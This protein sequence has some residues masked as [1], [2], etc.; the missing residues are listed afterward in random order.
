MPAEVAHATLPTP[1]KSPQLATDA[2]GLVSVAQAAPSHYQ[3]VVQDVPQK[4]APIWALLFVAVGVIGLGAVFVVPRLA[5]KQ[6]AAPP[7]PATPAAPATTPA[8]PVEATVETV[9]VRISVDPA[10]A[11]VKLDNVVLEGNPFVGAI[12][13]DKATHELT[14]VAEGCR[15]H[16]QSVNLSR[17]VHLL[18]AMKCFNN[19]IR[20]KA[21]GVAPRSVGAAAAAAPA[22]AP[23]PAP[24]A[25][26]PQPAAPAPAPPPALPKE[27][28]G[29]PGESKNEPEGKYGF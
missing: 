11:V 13:K 5:A 2:F 29:A 18:V 16:T 22:R 27:P 7:A 17:D 6:S 3:S 9:N 24:P 14:A 28:P 26:E 8:A 12:A 10:D 15:D 25:A 4:K 20:A 21:R 23:T 19:A 1:P